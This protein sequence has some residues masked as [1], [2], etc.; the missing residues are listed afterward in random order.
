VND[1]L[2]QPAQAPR[3]TNQRIKTMRRRITAA[4]VSAHTKAPAIRSPGTGRIGH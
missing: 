3:L 4:P 1:Q 2:P